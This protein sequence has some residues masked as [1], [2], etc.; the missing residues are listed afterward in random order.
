M[1]YYPESAKFVEAKRILGEI[2]LDLLISESPAPWK[3][4]YTV[5]SGDPGLAAIASRHKTTV[6]FIMRA[7]GA[8]WR[9]HSP[10]R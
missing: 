3:D 1:R 4:K 7:N 6:D 8:Q 9:S 2:N 5:K 10:G